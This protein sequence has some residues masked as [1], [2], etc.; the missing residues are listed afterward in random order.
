LKGGLGEEGVVGVMLLLGPAMGMRRMG[1]HA[2]SSAREK[3]DLVPVCRPGLGKVRSGLMK[4][5]SGGGD[6]AM[7]LSNRPCTV[8]APQTCDMSTLEI[9]EID[10]QVPSLLHL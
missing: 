5:S 3:A 7:S 4:P 2:W 8:A 6:V 1:P 10:E 9:M